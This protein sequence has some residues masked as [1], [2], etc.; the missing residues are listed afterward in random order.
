MK[1]WVIIVN[2]NEVRRYEGTPSSNATFEK[3][4]MFEITENDIV[5]SLEVYKN[6]F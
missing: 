2:E 3:I 6:L 1:K 4:N 5:M